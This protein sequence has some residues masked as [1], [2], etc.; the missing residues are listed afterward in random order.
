[1]KAVRIAAKECNYQELD[2]CIKEHFTHGID[3]DNMLIEISSELRGM[4]NMSRVTS[5]QVLMWAR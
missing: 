4:K 3:D 1:M 5:N 2:R